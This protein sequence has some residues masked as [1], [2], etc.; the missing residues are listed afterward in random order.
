MDLPPPEK[1]RLLIRHHIKNIIIQNLAMFAVFFSEENQLPEKD[2][3]KI[4][5][6]KRKF[7]R[8]V[9]EIIEAGIAQ[10]YFRPADAKLQAYAIIGMCNWLYR[11]YKPGASPYT[12][13]EIADHFIG[14]LES[15]Y[16]RVQGQGVRSVPAESMPRKRELI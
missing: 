4:R 11:W 10:G 1:L 6:E 12:P 8:V 5:E 14:L 16:M 3:Q 9:Q 13:D 7:T 2:C 15:G